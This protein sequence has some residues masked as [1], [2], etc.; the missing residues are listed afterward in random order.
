MPSPISSI[1]SVIHLRMIE[2][3]GNIHLS[4]THQFNIQAVGHEIHIKT[5]VASHQLPPESQMTT[6]P[7]YQ[8]ILHSSATGVPAILYD[9]CTQVFFF[10]RL[11]VHSNSTH[12]IVRVERF[13]WQVHRGELALAEEFEE[14]HAFGTV[15]VVKVHIEP[16]VGCVGYVEVVDTE[17][18]LYKPGHI[19]LMARTA[20]AHEMLQTLR[21][22]NSIRF[23]GVAAPASDSGN[24][25]IALHVS[26]SSG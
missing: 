18:N 1:S 7:E 2:F 17:M 4:N 14:T 13:K 11:L 24:G 3:A 23:G 16:V 10:G 5:C 19:K 26:R 25:L 8:F 9:F 15:Y 6:F 12:P 21:R 20:Q 22:G